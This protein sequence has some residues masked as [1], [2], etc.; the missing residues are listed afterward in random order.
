MR[1]LPGPSD[2]PDLLGPPDLSKVPGPLDLPDLPE[3]SKV[4]GPPDLPDL[5]KVPDQANLG[6]SPL[7]CVEWCPFGIKQDPALEEKTKLIWDLNM[8]LL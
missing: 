8:H 4:S 5:S 1:F 7:L 3:L 2:L 6:D